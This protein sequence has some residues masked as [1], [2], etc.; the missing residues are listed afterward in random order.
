MLAHAAEIPTI[1]SAPRVLTTCWGA[2]ANPVR[3]ARHVVNIPWAAIETVLIVL[4]RKGPLCLMS[5][6]LYRIIKIHVAQSQKVRLC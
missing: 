4:G 5:P 2:R 6:A 1:D 3:D